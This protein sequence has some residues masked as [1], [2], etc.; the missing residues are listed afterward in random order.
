MCYYIFL[1]YPKDNAVLETEQ[2]ALWLAEGLFLGF[3]PSDLPLA[4]SFSSPKS[5]VYA[6]TNTMAYTRCVS[7]Y[8]ERE[9]MSANI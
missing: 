6:D 4:R 7:A 3:L 5:D 9:M 8:L 1:A 2:P